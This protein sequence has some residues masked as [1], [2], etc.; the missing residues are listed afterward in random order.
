[1]SSN[2]RPTWVT[3]IGVITLVFGLF[4]ILGATQELLTPR[5]IDMQQTVEMHIHDMAKE[6]SKD[7]KSN[8][9]ITIDDETLILSVDEVMAAVT[10]VFDVPKWFAEW[11]FTIGVISMAIA[12]LY[13]F[14]GISLL[15]ANEISLP[16]FYCV[17]GMSILWEIIRIALFAQSEAILLLVQI[18]FSVF[19]I[20]IDVILL[21]I[22]LT[23]RRTSFATI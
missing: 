8:I 10:D 4:S 19:S 22:V 12:L 1:M 2:K 16:I 3:A 17:M 14:G 21:L 6:S 9:K 11:A 18:P 15:M 23:S 5:F 7:G 20:I 13:C